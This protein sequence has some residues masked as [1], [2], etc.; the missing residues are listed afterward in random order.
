MDDGFIT[1]A[2]IVFSPILLPL[3]VLAMAF[4]GG[5]ALWNRITSAKSPNELEKELG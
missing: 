4:L 2:L 3:V 5:L 1:F